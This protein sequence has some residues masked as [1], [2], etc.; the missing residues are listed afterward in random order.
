MVQTLLEDRFKLKFHRETKELPVFALLVGK[1][2][3]KLKP[4]RPEDDAART[5]KG[6]QGGEG[7]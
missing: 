5:V 4:T 1:N 3:P 6:F 7:N 2:G